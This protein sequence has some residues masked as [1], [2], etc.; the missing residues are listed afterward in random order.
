MR[1][2]RLDRL[3][4][5]PSEIH[6]RELIRSA[7]GPVVVVM[8]PTAD[9]LVLGSA[10]SPS[11]VDDRAALTAGVEVVRRRSGGGAVLVRGAEMTWFDV[12]VPAA[13]GGVPDDVTASMRWI[14]ERVA[15]ALGV[16]GVDGAVAHRGPMRT[17]AWSRLVCFDGLAPG[18]V[19]IASGG[20]RG[21]LVGVSQRRTRD[22]CRFQCMVHNRWDPTALL[23]LLADPKPAPDEVAPVATIAADRAEALPAALVDALAR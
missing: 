13:A 11:V 22:G 17:T 8:T 18:E 10:Q 2:V 19:T 21:K 9:A 1:G 16:L 7:T 3:S 6:R 4:G 14:G 15:A 23:G 12:V 20:R 5:T